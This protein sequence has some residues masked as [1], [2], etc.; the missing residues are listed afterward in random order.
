MHWPG[1]AWSACRME[2]RKDQSSCSCRVEEPVLL[3]Q[4]KL[5]ARLSLPLSLS[6]FSAVVLLTLFL[7]KTWQLYCLPNRPHL[8]SKAIAVGT[9]GVH[10]CQEINRKSF[11]ITKLERKQIVG[12]TK[13]INKQTNKIQSPSELCV[14]LWVR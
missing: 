8:T 6:L 13:K 1:H 9:E 4:L 12:C 7:W 14:W 2:V 5:S 11:E 10:A 3:Q